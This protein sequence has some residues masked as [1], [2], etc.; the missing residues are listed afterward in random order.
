MRCCRL[1]PIFFATLLLCAG[2]NEEA[3]ITPTVETTVGSYNQPMEL[4]EIELPYD[5]TRDT[6]STQSP[7]LTESTTQIEKPTEVSGS[8]ENSEEP[9]PS[10]EPSEEP[11]PSEQDPGR[12]EAPTEDTY[13][14]GSTTGSEQTVVSG[15]LSCSN[16]GRYSGSFVEN[17]SDRRV[18]NVAVL[19][20]TNRSQEYL[21]FA[22]LTFTIGDKE[23]VFEATGIPPGK[24]A[25]VMEK[26][27]LAIDQG[28]VFVCGE[29]VTSFRPVPDFSHL[30]ISAEDGRLQITNLSNEPM[31]DVYIYYKN[32]HTDGNFLGGIT[33]RVA[34]DKLPAA[35]SLLVNA[36]HSVENQTEIVCV[37]WNNAA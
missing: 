29:E 26:N 24:S 1:I 8:T 23:A 35:Q 4:P 27:G 2:C 6:E 10:T 17:G 15:K 37:T 21:D 33:Y 11:L 12:T 19:L 14:T 22:R 28:A 13:G 9:M 36:G 32:L 18:E 7:E 3:T 31:E 5:D 34:A 30:K 20:L 16:F 25:W